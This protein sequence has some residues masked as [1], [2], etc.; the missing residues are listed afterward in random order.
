MDDKELIW[1]PKEVADTYN[2]V[3]SDATQREQQQKIIDDYIQ[4]L[5]EKSKKEYQENLSALD[6]EAAIFTG[7][8][9]RIKQSFEAA[10][11]AA[12]KANYDVWERFDSERTNI[13]KKVSDMITF[14]KPLK[15]ELS[16][17]SS[18]LNKINTYSFDRLVETLLKVSNL[19]GENKEMF[20]FLI[21]NYKIN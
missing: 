8:N 5:S 13:S 17:I 20:D 12:K 21:K 10:L 18:I 15:G 3:T 7:L 9:L 6:E 4:S 1:V 11:D 19:Q 16:E 14:L 2:K